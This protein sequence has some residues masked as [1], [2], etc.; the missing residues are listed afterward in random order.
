MR[1]SVLCQQLVD[2]LPTVALDTLRVAFNKR[3]ATSVQDFFEKTN[4]TEMW[5]GAAAR[6]HLAD[7]AGVLTQWANIEAVRALL[8][9]LSSEAV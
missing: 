4:A 2:E 3:G 8:S 1:W 5:T 7:L 6:R 9:A